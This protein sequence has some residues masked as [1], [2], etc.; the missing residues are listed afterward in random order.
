MLELMM[1]GGGKPT[2]NLGD[3]GPGP[4]ELLGFTK[5]SDTTIAGYYGRVFYTDLGFTSVTEIFTLTG[6]TSLG[7]ALVSIPYWY[8]KFHI[9]GKTLFVPSYPTKCSVS[10]VDLYSLGLVYGVDSDGYKP[11]SVNPKN[12]LKII[13]FGGYRYL[14]RLLKGSPDSPSSINEA[15]EDYSSDP[16]SLYLSEWN[17]LFY[18][19]MPGVYAGQHG[20]KWLPTAELI[21]PENLGMGGTYGGWQHTQ[22]LVRSNTNNSLIR[23]S[24]TGGWAMVAGVESSS[25]NYGW[26]FALELI[27]KA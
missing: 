4:T 20:G 8:L 18:P 19:I 7:T 23:G 25:D 2:L 21:L 6:T 27:G 22:E 26:R 11:G 12:Q 5:D 16:V 24:R 13:T 15:T 14:V 9:D 1:V 17:R 10:W 3:S